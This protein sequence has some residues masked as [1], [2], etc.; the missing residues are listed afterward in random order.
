LAEL[1][2]FETADLR[3]E[4]MNNRAMHLRHLQEVERWLAEGERHISEQEQRI[5]TLRRDGHD[6]TRAESLLEVFYQTQAQHISH[7]DMIL[8]ELDQ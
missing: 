8:K 4:L 7:R 5:A 2:Q 3:V 1:A 6:A